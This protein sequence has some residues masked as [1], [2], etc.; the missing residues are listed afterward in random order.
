MKICLVCSSGGHFLELHSLD[1]LW[2]RYDRCWVT[3]RT[4]DTVSL[5]AG[6]R[7][8]WA[9][10]PTTRNIPNLLRNLAVAARVL[11]REKPDAIISSGAGVAVPFIY[12]GRAL[13]MTTIYIESLTRTRNLSL[14]GRLVYP[15][16][17][18]FLVQWPEL[19]ARFRRA[20]FEGQVL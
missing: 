18:R 20:R 7:V 4:M 10:R 14:T 11:P 6:E 1:E 12:L 17:H 5:L 2:R 9:H 16:A 15:V 8:Y 13:G 3:F 19:A